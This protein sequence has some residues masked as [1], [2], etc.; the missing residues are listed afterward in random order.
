VD[1][2]P[3][4]F[5]LKQ[6]RNIRLRSNVR[7]YLDDNHARYPDWS[8]EN[9]ETAITSVQLLHTSCFD[10][11]LKSE[12]DDTPEI[13][14]SA[15]RGRVDKNFWEAG[16]QSPVAKEMKQ[17]IDEDPNLWILYFLGKPERH[18]NFAGFTKNLRNQLQDEDFRRALL[19]KYQSSLFSVLNDSVSTECPEL[20]K[21]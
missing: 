2:T 4:V 5:A 19:K 8:L 13:G 15:Q 10:L 9:I 17:E 20:W 21:C 11:A 1:D 3:H 7:K 12:C 14:I 16:A 18:R 6:T